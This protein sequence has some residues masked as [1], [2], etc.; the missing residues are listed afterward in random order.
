MISPTTHA[1]LLL[2]VK[3]GTAPQP[4]GLPE[5][6]VLAL[7]LDERGLRPEHLVQGNADELL[8]DWD[9]PRIERERLLRLL[10]RDHQLAWSVEHWRSADIWILGRSDDAYPSRLKERLRGEA[11][12]VLF[13]AGEPSLLLAEGIA[14]VG[15][16]DATVDELRF[17]DDLGAVVSEAGYNVVSGGARG[18]DERAAQGAFRTGGSVVAVLAESLIRNASKKLYRDHLT[19]GKLV[20]TTPYS[21]DMGFKPYRA[22][23]RNAYI[24]CLSQAG[25]V[26]SST[27]GSGGT[28]HGASINLRGGWVP[29]WVMTTKDPASG[30]HVLAANGARWLPPLETLNVE[31]L[32]APGWTPPDHPPEAPHTGAD[33]LPEM[34]DGE[35]HRAL[36]S[37]YGV[38]VEHWRL[39]GNDPVTPG[40]MASALGIHVKQAQEWLDRGVAEGLAT[41]MTSPVRYQLV[42]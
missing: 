29:L 16:R 21:P 19:Q 17:A 34:S 28:F 32:T 20:L 11:P 30:N 31:R 9:D 24:Y 40:T 1:T 35:G 27:N 13:G 18:V 3:L 23:E 15:S 37:L 36:P 5:W 2:M 39:L 14:I 4:L 25:V 33:A 26:V 22:M 8:R 42:S 38:F 41:K 12:P 6:N 7:W 10:D